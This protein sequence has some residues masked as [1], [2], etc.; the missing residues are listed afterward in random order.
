MNH[1]VEHSQAECLKYRSMFGKVTELGDI[2]MFF[3]TRET[4]E[5]LPTKMTQ[6]QLW[7]A[8]YFHPLL[9]G[10]DTQIDVFKIQKELFV[11]A[12]DILKKAFL[13]KE[14]S[15]AYPVQRF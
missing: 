15:S 4:G 12:P 8:H 6:G 3:L 5:A 13:E 10:T 14:S 1:T 9:P 11:K 2:K 7:S